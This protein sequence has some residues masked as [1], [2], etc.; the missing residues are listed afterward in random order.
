[1]DHIPPMMA[2][3]SLSFIQEK[4]MMQLNGQ[5]QGWK[6][7]SDYRLD[8]EDNES[9][10]TSEGTPAWLIFNVRAQVQCTQQS[11]IIIG[12][13][14]ILDTQYR[15]FASGINSPGRNFYLSYKFNF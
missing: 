10:A 12:V 8:A 1:M 11:Q 5:Y 3:A 4:W 7:I 15:L 6:K 9:Y 13:D 2:N 14:N